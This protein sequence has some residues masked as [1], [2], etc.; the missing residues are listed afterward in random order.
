MSDT[1]QCNFL[2][3][4]KIKKSDLISL[5]CYDSLLLGLLSVFFSSL[6]LGV[7]R[8]FPLDFFKYT[9]IPLSLSP[10]KLQKCNTK[11][12]PVYYPAKIDFLNTLNTL[13]PLQFPT[14]ILFVFFSGSIILSSIMTPNISIPWAEAFLSYELL[15]LGFV[16]ISA[17]IFSRIKHGIKLYIYILSFFCVINLIINLIA[18]FQSLVSPFYK[19]YFAPTYAIV[20]DHWSTTAASVY[21]IILL[22]NISLNNLLHSFFFKFKN[23]F[24]IAAF[25][26]L[27]WFTLVITQSRGVLIATLV[28]CFNKYNTSRTGYIF[29]SSLLLLLLAIMLHISPDIFYTAIKRMDSDRFVI[30]GY[31]I[32]LC[33]ERPL[34]GY[35]ERLSIVM[36]LHNKPAIGHAHSIFLGAALRGGLISLLSLVA[37]FLRSFSLIRRYPME[38]NTLLLSTMFPALLIMGLVDFELLIMPPDWQWITFWFPISLLI[39]TEVKIHRRKSLWQFN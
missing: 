24:F 11:A 33:L 37:I 12:F 14:A 13:Y 8:D 2:K 22:S 18:Y 10:F 20:P 1:K 29:G 6:F 28:A 3:F 15:I 27:F 38:I 39:A 34:F 35:G 23:F 9:I 36:H 30:W 17:R 32:H 19:V 5:Q 16:T 31:Y 21:A 7:C 26:S 4:N 25:N